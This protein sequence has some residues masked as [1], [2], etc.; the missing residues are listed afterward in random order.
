MVVRHKPQAI[1]IRLDSQGWVEIDT[2]LTQ[3]LLHGKEIT[4]SMLDE[5]VQTSP[6]QRFAISEDG[7]CIRASQGHSVN[8]D[9][10][11]EPAVPP[12]VL[13]H[14]TVADRVESIRSRGLDRM[15]RHHVHLSSDSRT[16][17]AVGR[18]RGKPIVLRILSDRM[19]RDGYFFCMSTNGVWLTKAVPR[20][21][22][23]FQED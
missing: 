3:C 21:Y 16:A 13:F 2:L 23:D 7:L 11:Y 12:E 22:I 5:I 15:S 18:R 14:G 6:K 20:R 17:V 4:R 19:H 8:I 10:G 1:D 9:L